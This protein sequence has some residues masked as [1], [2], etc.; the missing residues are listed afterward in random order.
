MWEYRE[1]FVLF[2]VP[3]LAAL[4]MLVPRVAIPK[5]DSMLLGNRFAQIIL[6]D[7]WI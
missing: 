6:A 5:M 7:R 3:A 4:I 1:N 2:M